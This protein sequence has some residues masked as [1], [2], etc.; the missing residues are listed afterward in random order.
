MPV[1]DLLDYIDASPTPFHA[2]AETVKRLESVG[3]TA[4]D[5]ADRWDVEAG[6]KIFVIRGGGSLAAFHVGT[7]PLE[8]PDFT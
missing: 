8:K 4:L 1:Q 7:S 6:D 3:Y 2:V 5:E